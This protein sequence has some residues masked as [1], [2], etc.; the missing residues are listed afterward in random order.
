MMLFLMEKKK[1]LIST[2]FKDIAF[3]MQCEFVLEAKR[4]LI[5]YAH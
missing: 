2:L 4:N 1:I 3:A 5:F